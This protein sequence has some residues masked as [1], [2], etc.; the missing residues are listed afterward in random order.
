MKK[1]NRIYI[2]NNGKIIETENVKRK[3]IN[4]L[5]DWV[6]KDNSQSNEIGFRGAG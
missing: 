6:K 4:D 2:E 5:I 3:D 1:K